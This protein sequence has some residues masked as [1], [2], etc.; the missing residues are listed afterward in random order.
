MHAGHEIE[1]RERV[2]LLLPADDRRH[3]VVVAN[4]TVGADRR[5]RPAVIHQQLAAAILV[6][7][8]V[9]VERAQDLAHRLHAFEIL[10]EL[11]DAPGEGRVVGLEREE[12]HV[13]VG[14]AVAARQAASRISEPAVSLLRRIFRTGNPGA[15]AAVAP[16]VPEREPP[17]VRLP[18]DLGALVD[19]LH[20]G[21]LAVVE[22]VRSVG[23]GALQGVG[24]EAAGARVGDQAVFEAVGLVARGK[25]RLRHQLDLLRR[26]EVLG[27]GE[28]LLVDQRAAHLHRRAGGRVAADDAVEVGRISLHFHQRLAA[29][30]RAAI[31]VGMLHRASVERACE[32]LA[33]HG[34]DVRAAMPVVDLLRTVRHPR[35]IVRQVARVG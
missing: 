8:Q 3:L 28:H 34:G 23:T 30:V 24:L 17:R 7:A 1:L 32:L 31:E 12:A 10:R 2:H 19:L 25:R 15:P 9:G 11:E 35:L 18:V 21:Q 14:E 29:T 26:Q 13:R 5:V 6:R 27:L 22:A 20:D 16:L 4:R 33:G